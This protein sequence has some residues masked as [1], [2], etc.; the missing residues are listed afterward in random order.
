M[1]VRVRLPC[2]LPQE[3]VL[4]TQ[5]DVAPVKMDASKLHRG[6]VNCAAKS[7]EH[8]HLIATGAADNSVSDSGFCQAWSPPIG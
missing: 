4:P 5:A 7:S 1:F 3:N 8:P 2:H 6:D